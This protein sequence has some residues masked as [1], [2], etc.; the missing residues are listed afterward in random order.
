MQLRGNR[1]VV[2]MLGVCGTTVVTEYYP[3]S[4]VYHAFGHR[5][6][7]P[8]HVVVSMSLDAARGLQVWRVLQRGSCATI[9]HY[10]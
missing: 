3:T 6:P 7:L 9:P 10:G 5:E 8:I 2:A 1:N 4:V